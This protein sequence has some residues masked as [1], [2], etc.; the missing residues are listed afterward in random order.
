MYGL[1]IVAFVII[2]LLSVGLL[3]LACF[4]SRKKSVAMFVGQLVFLSLAFFFFYRCI[5]YLPNQAN[6]MY[7]EDQSLTLGIAGILWAI[8]M[9]WEFVGICVLAWHGKGKN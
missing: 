8:S 9:L 3:V 5:S 4:K 1:I 6:V 2:M 7:T